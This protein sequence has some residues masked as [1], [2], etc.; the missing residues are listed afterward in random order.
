MACV[1]GGCTG[2]CKTSCATTCT[3]TCSATCRPYCGAD[4][5]G[6]EKI[7][8]IIPCFYEDFYLTRCLTSLAQ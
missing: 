2:T 6:L 1:V 8:I 5:T 3:G 4:C 7:N